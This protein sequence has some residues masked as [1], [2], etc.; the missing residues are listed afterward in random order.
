LEVTTFTA[1]PYASSTA[2]FIVSEMDGCGKT[3]CI[4]SSSVVSRFIRDD[5]SL[6]QF[7]DFGADE[8]RAEQLAGLVVEDHLAM[9]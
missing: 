1:L 9:P 3:V 6:N 2:S 4:S 8:M 7:G 5:E